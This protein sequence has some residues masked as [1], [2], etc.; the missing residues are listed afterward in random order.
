MKDELKLKAIQEAAQYH[1]KHECPACDVEFVV[2]E[3]SEHCPA[4]GDEHEGFDEQAIALAEH[5]DIDVG[6]VIAAYTDCYEANG[7][8]YLVL[9][10]GEA[11][12]KWDENLESYIEDC[13]MGELPDQFHD[14]FDRDGF[15]ESLQ[16][17]GRG[18][19]LNTY[20]GEEC[21]HGDY[22]IYRTN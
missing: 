1:A 2:T 7:G 5:L 15:K 9:T 22:Y 17:N 10:D 18:E 21:E 4:C 14:F 6:E 8:E 16:H 12:D 11:D 13:V 20:D 3:H 19:S